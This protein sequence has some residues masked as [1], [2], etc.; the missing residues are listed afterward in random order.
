M[1]VS[2][3]QAATI[4]HHRR[5]VPRST[6]FD[7]HAPILTSSSPPSTRPSLF[8][9][10]CFTSTQHHVPCP[11]PFVPI[12]IYCCQPGWSCCR[13]IAAVVL[14]TRIFS[15]DVEVMSDPRQG[16]MARFIRA[17]NQ[18][19][20]GIPQVGKNQQGST[21]ALASMFFFFQNAKGNV[22]RRARDSLS[23]FDQEEMNLQHSPIQLCILRPPLF[24]SLQ[25]SHRVFELVGISEN[26]IP[27]LCNGQCGPQSKNTYEI[28]CRHANRI[29]WST[30]KD[31]WLLLVTSYARSRSTL[32][33]AFGKAVTKKKSSIKSGEKRPGGTWYRQ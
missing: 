23:A 29:L 7:F 32:S 8:P 28:K 3:N 26:R 21:L 15:L 12:P 18:P 2:N 22:L 14:L 27:S 25:G 33:I 10:T 17:A 5:P 19:A 31:R 16:A 9:A 30:N 11:R 20:A 1:R 13:C 24:A 4:H 6:V